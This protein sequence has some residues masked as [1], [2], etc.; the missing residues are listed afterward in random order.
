MELNNIFAR[1]IDSAKSGE[2]VRIP[3]RL[4]PK[5]QSEEVKKEPPKKYVWQFLGANA[6]KAQKELQSKLVKDKQVIL[7]QLLFLFSYTH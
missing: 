1:A 3:N 4:M 2:K 6:V 5:N 7:L